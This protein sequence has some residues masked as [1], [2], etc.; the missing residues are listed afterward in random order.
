MVAERISLPL[1]IRNELTYDAMINQSLEYFL[2]RATSPAAEEVVE[3]GTVR[4]PTPDGFTRINEKIV[5]TS[6]Q[7]LFTAI[8]LPASE[9]L[10][11]ALAA[12]GYGLKLVISNEWV[13]HF[14]V[15]KDVPFDEETIRRGVRM[16]IW[17]QP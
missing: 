4:I 9:T 10:A 17:Q 3:S 5:I 13:K 8:E 2:T 7:T 15:R 1:T 6:G 14:L 12:G 11:D 16:S